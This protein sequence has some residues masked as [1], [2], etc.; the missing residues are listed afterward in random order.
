MFLLLAEA[1]QATEKLHLNVIW[2]YWIAFAVLVVFLLTLDLVVFHR[3]EHKPTMRE[4]TFF[5]IFW[6]AI[7]LIFNAFVYWWG[8][9]PS[10]EAV[11]A[12]RLALEAGKQVPELLPQAPNAGIDFL[13]GYLTEKMLSMDNIFVFVV[14][15]RYFSIPMKYQYR[16]LFWGIL[17][18]IIMRLLF[19]LAG[20]AL[21]NTFQGIMV[22]FGLFLIWTAW[23]LISHSGADVKP[24]N[25]F[26]LR[27]A[28][29][30]FR[31]TEEGHEVHGHDFFVRK[32]GLWY[33]TPMFLVLLVI[34]STDVIFAVDSIPA[35]FGI[36]QDIFIV[37]T[38]N[39]FAILGLRALY[40]LLAG[41]VETFRHLHYGLA[42]V[43]GFIGFKMIA[44]YVAKHYYGQEHLIPAVLCLGVIISLVAISILASIMFPSKDAQAEELDDEPGDD[45]PAD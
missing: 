16:V 10:P 30:Y 32:N 11:E 20:A 21:I 22:V 13:T 38:S 7:A 37:F 17:G 15:F 6:I 43:L 4:S 1:S 44:E 3:T 25:N 45:S 2:W 9:Q 41:A 34:E 39:I 24:E 33:I 5:T 8:N 27:F 23:K 36:T 14:V 35:I 40:F 19:I 18:A 29:K 28:K 26:V 12:A 42:A 31:V